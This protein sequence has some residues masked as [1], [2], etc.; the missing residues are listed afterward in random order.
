MN[1][2]TARWQWTT[3]RAALPDGEVFARP[4]LPDMGQPEVRNK[5]CVTNCQAFT[6]VYKF[7][8]TTRIPLCVLI[9]DLSGL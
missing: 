2:V 7:G 3:A 9:L 1:D 8:I 5:M 4:M 6:L